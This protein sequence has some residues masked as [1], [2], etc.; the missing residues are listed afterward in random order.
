MTSIVIAAHNEQAVIGRT[1]DALLSDPANSGVEIIVVAN[2]CTDATAQVATRPGVRVL[3]VAERGKA[4]ALNAGDAV[5]VSF[6]RLYLDADITVP[7]GGVRA[8]VDALG[9]TGALAAVPG[10]RLALHGRSLPVRAYFAIHSRLPVF[11]MGLFGRGLVALSQ[12]G[13]ARFGEFP[14]IVADDL[15]LDSLVSDQE[16]VSVPDV[17]VVVETPFDTRSLVRRLVRVRRG[18]AALRELGSSGLATVRPSDRWSWLRD[19]VLTDLRLAPA[20]VVYAALTT[21]AA[22]AARRGARTS[23]AWDRDES[24]RSATS[25]A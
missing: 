12:G 11:R 22:L 9:T 2:G 23:L 15:F 25:G 13:R 5:A 16:R 17:E 20:G 24:T 3:E 8:L 14:A 1:L 7:R 18:N 19:V 4:N 21:W 6:P 10:R